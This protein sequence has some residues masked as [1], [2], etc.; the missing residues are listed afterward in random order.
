MADE[1]K[2]G[3]L[4][5]ALKNGD[6]TASYQSKASDD[7]LPSSTKEKTPT[8]KTTLT[9]QECPP[10]PLAK[11]TDLTNSSKSTRNLSLKETLDKKEQV[12]RLEQDVQRLLLWQNPSRSGAYFI[13]I[14][15]GLILSKS[16]S[17]VQI[18]SALLTIV[19][20]VDLL[21][22]T[23]SIQTQRILADRPGVNPYR[24]L[25]GDDEITTMDRN[26]LQRNTELVADVVEA[27]LQKTLRIVLIEDTATSAKWLAIFYIVWK[28]SAIISVRTLVILLTFVLF[29]V[30][31]LYRYNKSFVDARIH[32]A[33][34]MCQAQLEHGRDKLQH[35]WNQL[36]TRFDL[37]DTGSASLS[38]TQKSRKEN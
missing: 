3:T 29:S 38:G 5:T 35:G 10:A 18:V 27:L 25:L 19:T 24:D 33:Q 23:F 32:H 2:S 12:K 11:S 7:R 22:V 16:H 1:T 9:A 6:T 31:L 34:S 30:P 36:C 26:F 13:L 14:V 4:D 17:L 37:Q 21:Y 28:L 15:S 8:A 20:G